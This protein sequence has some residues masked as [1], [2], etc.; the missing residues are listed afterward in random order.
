META[1]QYSIT[2]AIAAL[3]KLHGFI[4]VRQLHFLGDL[5]RGEEK[6]FFFNKMVEMARI[7]ETMPKVYEQEGK[8][9]EAIVYLHYFRGNQDWYITEKDSE[10]EQEQAYGLAD[11]G[12]GSESGY[13]S[14]V[15]IVN[16]KSFPWV[17]LDLHFTPR[18]LR[19]VKAERAKRGHS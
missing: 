5:M 16:M 6:Q 17:E 18:T 10:P 14:I 4:P 15:D 7:V 1:V 11:L 13:I 2:D 8:G 9:D 19:E 12:F 3:R